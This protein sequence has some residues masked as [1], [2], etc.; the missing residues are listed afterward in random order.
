MRNRKHLT[1]RRWN[2]QNNFDK[3]SVSKIARCYSLN[4]NKNVASGDSEPHLI[5]R[6]WQNNYCGG[7]RLSPLSFPRSGRPIVRC[8]LVCCKTWP[9]LGTAGGNWRNVK[10]GGGQTLECTRHQWVRSLSKCHQDT[11]D[12]LHISLVRTSSDR[13]DKR[14]AWKVQTNNR[15]TN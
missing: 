7:R 15:V 8:S 6:S 5:I 1:Q 10:W 9:S 13:R 14:G 3:Y 2:K 11:W 12:N 4:V